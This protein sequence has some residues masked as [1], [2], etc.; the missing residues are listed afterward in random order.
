MS[1]NVEI[2]KKIFKDI[3]NNGEKLTIFDVGTYDGSDSLEFNQIFPLAEIFSFDADNRSVELF[4]KE[5][6]NNPRIKLFETALSDVDGYVDWYSSNSETRRHYEY[7]DSWSASS[8]IKKPDN[9]LNIFKDISFSQDSKVKSTRLDTWIREHS[10][11]DSIDIMWVD[12][13]GGEREFIKG[14]LDTLKTKVKYLYIEFNGV[15][16]KKLYKD[17]FTSD[18]ILKHLDFFELKGTYNFMGNFGNVL[19]KNKRL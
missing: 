18:D 9:H 2:D 7:Q 14:G 5:V 19:L 4:K 10:Y 1:S 3:F 6:G 8:S 11:L 12:V 17:C 15:G 16:D 13:N